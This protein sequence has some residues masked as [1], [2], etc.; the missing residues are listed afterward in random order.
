[1]ASSGFRNSSRW[2]GKA[3]FVAPHALYFI[4]D[5]LRAV[6][7]RVDQVSLL[8]PSPFFSDLALLMPFGSTRFASLRRARESANRIPR[9]NL[10]RPKYFDLPGQ[11]TRPIT[12]TF[13]ARSSR[14]AVAGTGAHFDVFH[15]HFLGLNGFIGMALKERFGA[16]LVLT[17]YGG[18][19]YSVPFRNPYNR[20]LAESVVRAADGLIA[21]S[22]PIAENLRM[23]GANPGRVRV[24]PTGFDSSLFAPSPRGQAR[25]ALRL[26]P[27]KTI[28]LTVANLVPQKGH[29]FLLEA[30]AKASKSRDDLLLVLVGGGELEGEIRSTVARLGLQSKVELAGPHPHEEIATWINACDVFVLPSISEGSPT[31]LTEAMACGKPVVATNVGGIPDLVREGEEGHLLAPGNADALAD[32]IGGSL[33]KEWDGEAIRERALSFSWDSLASSIVRV[34]SEVSKI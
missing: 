6:E 20:R 28:L 11:F 32:A 30:L 25:A 5:Q 1:M 7:R 3:L 10:L 13:A 8:V 9:G 15:A 31:V 23:L 4:G 18:D 16:P 26:P 21:V 17:A 33:D 34:Y 27:E 19:A 12:D 24:I 22:K 14:R 2:P 29:R